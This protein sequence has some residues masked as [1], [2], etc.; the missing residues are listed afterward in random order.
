MIGEDKLL[1]TIQLTNLD[2]EEKKQEISDWA[3]LTRLLIQPTFIRS[4]TKQADPYNLRKLQEKIMLASV[5]DESW[6]VVGN[7]ENECSFRLEGNQLLIK[8]VLAI[9]VFK[10]NQFLIRD[11]IQKKMIAHGCLLYTSFTQT[12]RYP[13]RYN[14]PPFLFFI[15]KHLKSYPFA[16]VFVNKKRIKINWYISCLL[17]T[18]FSEVLKILF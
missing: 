6:L 5:R 4:F 14:Y 18:S 12:R 16:N 13:K 7:D 15:W 10:E 17:Y 1:M 11:F 9:S 3:V 2:D 8:N